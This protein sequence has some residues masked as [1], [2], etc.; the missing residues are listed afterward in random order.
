[1]DKETFLK[2][3]ARLKQEEG[4]RAAPYVDTT[5]NWTQG[6]GHKLAK[7]EIDHWSE[8]WA[9]A[10]LSNDIELVCHQAATLD[11]FCTL[12]AVRQGCILDMIFNLGL[13]EVLEFRNMIDAIERYDYERAAN[14]MLNSRWHHQVGNRAE[15]LAEIMR[16]GV[17][18]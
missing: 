17:G 7:R 1:M 10:V 16:T 2:L 15:R 4:F 11:W 6:Y 18:P 8:S 3:K 5:G 9:D 13:R 12:D 14:E